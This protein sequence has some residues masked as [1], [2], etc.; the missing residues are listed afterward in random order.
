MALFFSYRFITQEHMCRRRLS[1]A[2][3]RT[4]MSL[5]SLIIDAFWAH[6]DGAA[7]VRVRRFPLRRVR[8]ASDAGSRGALFRESAD[9]FFADFAMYEYACR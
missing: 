4:W 9:G 5:T 7:E 8:V 2:R 3:R 6:V 1:D